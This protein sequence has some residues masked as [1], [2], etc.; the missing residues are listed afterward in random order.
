MKSMNSKLMI[1][2]TGFALMGVG[3]GN[4]SQFQSIAEAPGGGLIGG[5]NAIPA[6]PGGTGGST[7]GGANG[8]GTVADFTPVSFEE[9][10]SYVATHPLNNPSNFKLSVELSNVGDNRYGGTVKI[11]Y[12]DAGQAYSGVFESGKSTNQKMSGLKDNGLYEAE[13]NYWYNSGGKSVFSGFFQDRYGAIIVVVDNVVNQGDGQGGGYVTGSVYYKN[14]AQSYATQSPY[15]KCW[16]IREGPYNCRA[17]SVMNKS[18][19]I[20]ADGYRKLGTFS[21]LVVS[22]AFK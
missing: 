2:L 10:N 6:P 16:F 7:P 17:G 11:S 14:F 4:S 8:S 1:L 5:E 21:G 22:E 20:P 15:R 3:C 13:Y 19:L 18:S 12:N 9:F